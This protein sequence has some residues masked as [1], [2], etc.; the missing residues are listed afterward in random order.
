LGAF[1]TSARVLP[2]CQYLLEHTHQ[3]LLQFQAASTIQEAIVREYGDVAEEDVSQFA[4]WLIHYCLHQTTY[5]S[6]L[7]NQSTISIISLIEADCFEA[8]EI[9]SRGGVA[10]CSGRFETS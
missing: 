1:K 3:P 10:S 4:G 9:H 5:L 2:K 7:L 8:D 6:L